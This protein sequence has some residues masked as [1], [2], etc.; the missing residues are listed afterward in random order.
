MKAP[1][2]NTPPHPTLPH[3]ASQGYEQRDCDQ[4]LLFING[5]RKVIVERSAFISVI[6]MINR[7]LITIVDLINR[8]HFA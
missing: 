4:L 2:H 1:Q 5:S 3:P 7:L 8:Q 6:R